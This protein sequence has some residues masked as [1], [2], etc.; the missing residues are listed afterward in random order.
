MS[1]VQ[2]V[3]L[4]AIPLRSGGHSSPPAAVAGGAGVTRRLAGLPSPRAGG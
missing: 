2:S 1:D 4:S 3:K